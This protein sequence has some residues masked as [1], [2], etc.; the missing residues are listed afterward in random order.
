MYRVHISCH[1]EVLLWSIANNIH[2]KCISSH[3]KKNDTN[4]H[5]T[6]HTKNLYH[7][8]CALDSKFFDMGLALYG[9]Y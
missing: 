6:K 4:V 5:L 8:L 2:N 3:H 9:Q 1:V 7:Q